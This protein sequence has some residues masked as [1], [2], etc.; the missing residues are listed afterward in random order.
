MRWIENGLL[1]V[2]LVSAGMTVSCHGTAE[3][4]PSGKTLLSQ[5][6]AT[7]TVKDSDLPAEPE[8]IVYGDMRFTHPEDTEDTNPAAR[9]ALVAKIAEEQPN[10][11]VLTGDVPFRGRDLFDY[12][13]FAAETAEWRAEH[14]RVYPVLGNHELSGT[15]LRDPIE[16]W[17]GAFPELKDRRWYSVALGSRIRIV[18]LDSNSALTPGSPQRSWLE[19]QIASLAP[20]ADFV[21][22]ALHHPPVADIQTRVHVDH[23]PRPNEIALRDYL[24]GVAPR[25]HAQFIVACGHIHNYER[26]SGDGVT[27]LVSGG[28]GARPHEID[29]TPAD[30]YQAKD[31]PVFHYIEFRLEGQE[32]KATMVRLG[33]PIGAAPVW[34]NADSFSIA[35]KPGAGR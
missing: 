5:P 21:F 32:L 19:E 30:Q 33:M 35:A 27:Y 6:G 23:N 9:R 20:T 29:R 7:F 2:A 13:E 3:D 10:A 15:G 26:F 11:L 34:T 31:F 12:Q 4:R 8:L 18:A 22:L 17:W 28:G 1:V 25:S 14:L 16:N 24:T